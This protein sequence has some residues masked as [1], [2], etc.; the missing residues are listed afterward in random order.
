MFCCEFLS[1]CC[2]A[3]SVAQVSTVV[4]RDCRLIRHGQIICRL[5]SGVG[6]GMGILDGGGVQDLLILGLCDFVSILFYV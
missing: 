3:C 6:R 2:T 1:W 5:S 4:G